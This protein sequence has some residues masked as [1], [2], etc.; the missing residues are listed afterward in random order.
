MEIIHSVVDWYMANLNYFTVFLL[1]VVESSFIPFPSE[2]V[3]PFAAYKAAQGNL[4]VYMVVL[5]GTTGA[6]VGAVI[7]Y[8]L[9][10]YLGRPLVYKFADSKPG[11][12]LLLSED[13]VAHAEDYFLRNGKLS[14]LI[15]RLVPAVRQ[16]ISIPAGLAKMNM[17]DFLIYTT[18]G[19]GLWNIILAVIGFY[20]YEIKDQIFPY[21]SHIL[22]SLGGLFVIYLVIKGIIWN[23]KKNKK[24][25]SGN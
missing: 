9:A 2:V 1:M 19:A 14:T 16:L 21:L 23:R 3:I 10:K 12:I 17:R 20:L 11:R 7:N 13:K 24:I 22:W 5:A 6:L 8:Y 25:Q 18:I 15:G 4:N